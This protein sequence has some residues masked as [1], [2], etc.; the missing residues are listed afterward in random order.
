M[1]SPRKILFVLNPTAGGGNN[2]SAREKI[3]TLCD[4][5]DLDLTVYETRGKQDAE[6]ITGLIEIHRPDRVLA[7]GGDGTIQLVGDI[8][9]KKGVE[10]GIIPLG[11]ANG[12]ATELGLTGPFV[13]A[14]DIALGA[15][16]IEM[17][18]LQLNDQ[19]C[20]HFADLGMNAELVKEY[21]DSG[22]GG[23]LGYVLSALR[24][25]V[26]LI[27]PFEIT[28]ESDQ[29]KKT[30]ET[31]I[32]F[33]AN[34]RKLGTGFVINPE[35]RIDDGQFEIC[36]LRSVDLS[37]ALRLLFSGEN[38]DERLYEIISAK[39]ATLTTSRPIA[40][41]MD[42]EYGGRL[43]RIQIGVGDRKLTVAVNEKNLS[44]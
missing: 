23:F 21:E 31:T 29:E 41:Q 20:Y 37:N 10:L 9:L 36:V 19:Q 3:E 44:A 4:D 39:E 43:D 2:E 11:S 16:T 1:D 7:G 27:D 38:T 28:I 32:A 42:G 17:D 15:H 40:F 35:G 24:R 14:M 34:A 18:V 26:E 33:I 30:L 12:L 13:D 22:S 6:E 25:N 8:C 5:R